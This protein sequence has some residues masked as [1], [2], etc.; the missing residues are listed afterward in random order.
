MSKQETQN[1]ETQNQQEKKMTSGT[2]VLL[3]FAI[4]FAA[5]MILEFLRQ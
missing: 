4:L 3:L 5:I 2:W 1:Q